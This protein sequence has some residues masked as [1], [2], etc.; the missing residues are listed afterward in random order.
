MTEPEPEG[1]TELDEFIE[2]ARAQDI[3][4]PQPSLLARKQFAAPFP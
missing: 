1:A 4:A 3:K 2:F